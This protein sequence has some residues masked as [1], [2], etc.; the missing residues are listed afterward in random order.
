MVAMQPESTT[1]V[2]AACRKV[3]EIILSGQSIMHRRPFT[4]KQ[5]IAMPAPGP[6]PVF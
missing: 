5:I 6:A 2:A 3:T 4:V 1:P